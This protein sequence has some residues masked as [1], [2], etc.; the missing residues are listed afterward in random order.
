MEKKSHKLALLA[1]DLK[2]PDTIGFDSYL[3]EVCIDL[4]SRITKNENDKINTKIRQDLLGIT[5]IIFAKY[6]SLP[7]IIGDRL[8]RVFDTNNNGVLEYNEFKT[9]MFSLFCENYE[10]SLRFIFD[11]YDFD[12]DGKISKEDIR[13]VL[14]Y[15]SYTNENDKENIANNKNIY[16]YKIN[17]LL[18]ICFDKMPALIDYICFS[19]IIENINSDIYFMIYLFLLQKKPFC[20]K[21]I[22]LYNKDLNT[23]LNDNIG[24]NQTENNLYLGEINSI[25]NS[26]SNN[27]LKN[28]YRINKFLNFFKSDTNINSAATTYNTKVYSPSNIQIIHKDLKNNNDKNYKRR[29]NFGKTDFVK[30]LESNLFEQNLDDSIFEGVIPENIIE[31]IDKIKYNDEEY[32]NEEEE[33]EKEKKKGTLISENNNYEGYIY[34]LN[35]GKMIKIWFKLFYKDLF[36]FKN[37]LDTKHKGMH[38]LSGLFLK[39][40]ATK[41]LDDKIYYSFSIIFPTK[42]RIYFSDD[43]TEFKKWKKYLRIATNYSNIL[44]IYTITT[45][46][47]S[48]AFS[49]VK[50][51]I[52]K[53]TKQKVAVKIMD[54]MK[55]NSSRLESARNE[56][57]IMKIC[58]FPYII[59]YIEAFENYDNIYIF[60]EYCPGGTLY[61]FLKKRNFQLKESL[62]AKIIYEICLAIFYFHSYGIA[63]RDLKPENILMTSEENDADIRILDFGL[64]KIIGPNQK[65][66]EPYGTI[67]YCA[68]E[69]ILNKP[70]TKIVDLWSLGII[71][72]ILLYG[73]LPFWD[74]EKKTLKKYIVKYRPIYR[75]YDLADISE[76]GINFV[77]NLLVK[78]PNKRMNVSQALKHKWFQKH[79]INNLIKLSTLNK[80]GNNMIEIL[81][82]INKVKK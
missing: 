37:R 49:H 73:R 15:V 61:N 40:E 64:G 17:E 68:P 8:F 24:I 59:K 63:H 48:G 35:N 5:K 69:I 32:E 29:Q 80:D 26:K 56:I 18:N 44:Q 2:L 11:F 74:K 66:S 33:I 14:L 23:F 55:M 75:G 25:F 82:L 47:G 1:K 41:I 43:K 58:Q 3:K 70:Y 67:Y 72:Y 7:G 10:N 46:L 19:N 77:Q 76:E 6:Y 65:C 38:N 54:K 39:E 12:G 9:G 57:E 16:E 79:N 71:S 27:N 21:I 53:V 30:N 34:K 60:M 45:I 31:E 52:N 13:I 4:I 20:Y 28:S 50:L 62:A 36:F 42:K 78:D 81:N 51:A 22:N